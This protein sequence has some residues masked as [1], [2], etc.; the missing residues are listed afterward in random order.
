MGNGA[1]AWRVVQCRTLIDLGYHKARRRSL[2]ARSS[3][4]DE[5]L[6]ALSTHSQLFILLDMTTV[7]ALITGRPT[8]YPS[9][10]CLGTAMRPRRV[11]GRSER[12]RRLPR[13]WYAHPI[14]ASS[15]RRFAQSADT[16]ST[17]DNQVNLDSP[18]VLPSLHPFNT[19]TASSAAREGMCELTYPVREGTSTS[20]EKSLAQVLDACAETLDR[21]GPKMR[22]ATVTDVNELA[23][24]HTAA[25]TL[26]LRCSPNTTNNP[27]WTN[28][29]VSS[30]RGVLDTCWLTL[31]HRRCECEHEL[32][33]RR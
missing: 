16:I 20:S 32:V 30:N 21:L 3:C 8:P 2:F 1:V 18:P 12:S 31:L 22:G 26:V 29:R 17:N 11:S 13:T 33:T 23:M 7:P 27:M 19:Q 24:L 25:K 14:S 4:S 15:L 10:R 5:L 28:D 6:S 9:V